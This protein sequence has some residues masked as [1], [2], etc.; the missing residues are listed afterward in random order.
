MLTASLSRRRSG[1]SRTMRVVIP[2]MVAED[3]NV[4]LQVHPGR[5]PSFLRVSGPSPANKDGPTWRASMRG[6]R[7]PSWSSGRD[8]ALTIARNFAKGQGL[9]AWR[10]LNRECEANDEV[11]NFRLLKR[12]L[13]ATQ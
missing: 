13:H 10:R 12:V 5:S 6:C 8:E 9:D 2:F 3:I 11:A 1:S 7:L 4:A